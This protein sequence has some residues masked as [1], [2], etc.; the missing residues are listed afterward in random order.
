V[1]IYNPGRPKDQ[2]THPMP[3]P[4]ML[5]PAFSSA[6]EGVSTGEDSGPVRLDGKLLLVLSFVLVGVTIAH[7]IGDAHFDFGIFYYAAHMVFDGA[8]HALYDLPT[9]HAFQDQFHRAA[10]L[11]FRNPPFVLIPFLGIAKLPIEV[12]FI[13]WTAISLALFFLSVR[14]LARHAGLRYGNWPI[15]LSLVFAPVAW[16]LGHGQFSLLVL[17][18][19][20]L[21]YSLWRRGRFFLGGLALSVA[22]FKFQLVVGFVAVLLLKR[23]WREVLGFTTGSAIFLA[24]SIAMT[25]IPA[26]L[27][28]PL[29]VRATEGGVGSQ[30][31]YKMASW[32]GLLSLVGV[33]HAIVVATLSIVTILFCA[34]LWRDL[35]TG[36]VAAI[37]A[38]MLVS[39]HFS[40]TDLSLF[41]IPCFLSVRIG[42]PKKHLM[43]LVLSALFLPEILGAF[44]ARYALLAIP[45][46]TCLWWIWRQQRPTSPRAL[47]AAWRVRRAAALPTRPVDPLEP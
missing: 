38:T 25:G 26:L 41:L 14:A 2:V 44:G 46:A 30:E 29:F 21:T 24:I 34:H 12:A 16:T 7:Q 9:Q 15:L 35:D 37:L 43:P 39:Y 45:L 6:A 32:R 10:N 19:Y 11:P 18:A 40:L 4:E 31:P 17:A 20:V 36:F 1:T 22:T 3:H 42:F 8:R 13:I 47:A 27:S 33:D 23:K 28:Y 5:I